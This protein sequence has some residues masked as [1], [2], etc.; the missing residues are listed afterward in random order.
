MDATIGY[1]VF[2]TQ[3]IPAGTITWVRDRFD[4]SFPAD[5]VER[6]PP[7]LA[8]ALLRYAYRDLDGSYV[9]CWDHARFN[10][11]ACDPSCR[12]VGDFDIAVRDIPTGGELTIDY[13]A[14]NVPEE[15]AC[16]CGSPACRRTIRAGDADRFGDLWDAQVRSAAMRAASVT[17]PLEELFLNSAALS[18]ALRELRQGGAPVLPGAR[19]LIL[20][21]ARAR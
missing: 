18:R 21:A 5:M 2:A 10:N 6:L 1:G 8:R 13:A 14:I 12:T 19:D 4:Q 15:L 20:R 17:Q 11:H 16:G 9:L 7:V 3:P